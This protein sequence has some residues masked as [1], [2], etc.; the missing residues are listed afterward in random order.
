MITKGNNLAT[1]AEEAVSGIRSLTTTICLVPSKPRIK[2]VIAA[3]KLRWVVLLVVTKGVNLPLFAEVISGIVTLH[4]T[5][6]RSKT[7]VTSHWHVSTAD[8]GGRIVIVASATLVYLATKAERL[9]AVVT[10][11]RAASNV[12]PP[13]KRL[14]V[15]STTQV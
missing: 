15:S 6:L 13:G 14:N 7:T 2:R 4:S 3:G 10:F 12:V 11:S 5:A 8:E 9:R 1:G